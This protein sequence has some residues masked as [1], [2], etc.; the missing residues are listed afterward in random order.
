[1]S[2]I[3]QNGNSKAE[4]RRLLLTSWVTGI[5]KNVLKLGL[6]INPQFIKHWW[7]TRTYPYTRLST[8]KEFLLLKSQCQRNCNHESGFGLASVRLLSSYGRIFVAVSPPRELRREN[9]YK[10]RNLVSFRKTLSGAQNG[11]ILRALC[12][13]YM[14]PNWVISSGRFEGTQLLHLQWS[15][16]PTK[17]YVSSKRWELITQFGVVRFPIEK[18][19]QTYRHENLIMNSALC[20]FL[21]KPLLIHSYVEIFSHAPCSQAP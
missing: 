6:L 13:R 11:Q 18:K 9:A 3:Y 1:M 2:R 17:H 16:A 7:R 5:E 21:Q 8:V 20:S 12:F 14:T 10:C 15:R 19:S 4:I